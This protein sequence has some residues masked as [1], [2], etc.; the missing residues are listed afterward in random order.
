MTG[1][2]PKQTGLFMTHP[3]S[4]QLSQTLCTLYSFLTSTETQRQLKRAYSKQPPK[5]GGL[6]SALN[7]P[8][9]VHSDTVLPIDY[10]VVAIFHAGE[11]TK[12]PLP[13]LAALSIK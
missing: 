4:T 13:A 3:C 7:L 2:F 8:L 6:I 12:E 1:Y 5:C 9:M 10:R 11:H